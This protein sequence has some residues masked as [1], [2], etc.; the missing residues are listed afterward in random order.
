MKE[1]FAQRLQM[2]LDRKGMKAAELARL[3][4]TPESVINKK[5]LHNALRTHCNTK[6][7]LIFL[8]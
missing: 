7:F 1:T 5:S 4:G 8:K 6:N 2:A 3:T